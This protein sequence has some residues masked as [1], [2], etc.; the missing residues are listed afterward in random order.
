MSFPATWFRTVSSRICPDIPEQSLMR[1]RSV[2]L[3]ALLR[4][5]PA[6]YSSSCNAPS[7]AAIAIGSIRISRRI[8]DMP[9]SL[10]P[11]AGG[12]NTGTWNVGGGDRPQLVGTHIRFRMERPILQGHTL[13]PWSPAA[14]ERGISRTSLRNR[15]QQC[16]PDSSTVRGKFKSTSVP[17]S[18]LW[19][20]AWR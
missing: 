9:G 15:A 4:A 13:W 19:R 1:Q 11:V 18:L 2:C 5:L 3:T 17:P 16:S 12:H 20:N 14:E 7:Y 6:G 8:Q 10:E